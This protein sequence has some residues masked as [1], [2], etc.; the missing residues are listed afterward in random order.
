MQQYN[1]FLSKVKRIIIPLPDFNFFH[2]A[3]QDGDVDDK[4]VG[5]N[6]I[7][8]ILENWLR[9]P[10]TTNDDRNNKTADC[11]GS[12]LITGYRGM[13]KTSF[14]GKVI[15]KL[16]KEQ[17]SKWYM[18]WGSSNSK[19]RLAFMCMSPILT[20]YLVYYILQIF[21]IIQV[22]TLL[23]SEEQIRSIITISIVAPIYLIIVIILL[24]KTAPII[25]R[26][27]RNILK[28]KINIGNEVSDIRDIF[29]LFAYS[30]KDRLKDHI[31]EIYV[32]SPT[33]IAF[34]LL[35][36]LVIGSCSLILFVN[37]ISILTIGTDKFYEET[38][39]SLIFKLLEYFNNVG[40]GLL[41]GDILSKFIIVTIGFAY[42]TSVAYLIWWGIKKISVR[43]THAWNNQRYQLPEV[44]LNKMKQL[45]DRIDSSISEDN[46]PYG[47]ISIASTINVMYRRKKTHQYQYASVREI[48]YELIEI[49]KEINKSKL[50]NCRFIFVLDELDKLCTSKDKSSSE[51]LSADLPG[52]TN[53]DNGM[54]DEMTANEKRHNTLKLLS[55]LKYFV[56]TAEAK[57][58]FIAGHELYDAYK[59]DVSDREFSISSIF[60]GVINVNSFF[61][62]DSR[63]KDVTRM[64]ETYLC[65]VLF[66]EEPILINSSKDERDRFRLGEYRKRIG[67]LN[68][69]KVQEAKEVESVMCLL[70]QF[71]TYLTFVS[72]GAPKKLSARLERYII[73]A[74]KFNKEH[75]T[76]DSIVV[77]LKAGRQDIKYYLS[78]G[79]HDRQKVGFVHNMAAP[80]FDNIISPSSDYGDKFLV[81]S[82]FLIAHIYKH[83][84]SGFS[85]RNLEYLPELMDTN[86]TPELREFISSIID[87]LGKVHLTNITSGIFTYKFPMK[88]AEEIAI[89]TK[90]SDELSA[91]FNFSLDYFASVKKYYYRLIEFY[92]KRDGQNGIISSIH[93]NLGDIHMANDE[94]SE[95]IV[96]YRHAVAIIEKELDKI[97]QNDDIHTSGNYASYIIRYA[98]M[99]LKLGLA[100]E[101]RNT[102]DSAHMIYTRLCSRLIAYRAIDETKIGLTHYFENSPDPNYVKNNWQGKVAILTKGPDAD[103][104]QSKLDFQ[105]KCYPVVID[106][107]VTDSYQFWMYGGELVNNLCEFLTP[108]KHSLITKLSVFEDL[109]IAYL[110]ILAKLLALE[111]HNICGITKDNI[112]IAEAEFQHLYI[113][114]N[115]VDKYLL[116]VDFFRKLGDIMYYKNNSYKDNTIHSLMYAME[117]WGYDLRGSIFN[118]CYRRKMTKVQ[119]EPLIEAF[120][121]NLN[122]A[123]ISNSDELVSAIVCE[124]SHK[125]PVDQ[126]HV[127]NIIDEMPQGI[128]SNINR[129]KECDQR[130]SNLKC[131]PCYACKYYKR[132]LN[133]LK[134]NLLNIS[135]IQLSEIR[136]SDS[137][138]FWYALD[139]ELLFSCRFNELIQTALSL[140]S[141]GNVMLSCGAVGNDDIINPLNGHLLEA[142]FINNNNASNFI[143]AISG[144]AEYLSNIDKAILYYWVAM[145]YYSKAGNYKESMQ[146]LTKIFNTISSYDAMI[147]KHKKDPLSFSSPESLF[148]SMHEV[149][150]ETIRN[151]AQLRAFDNTLE[152]QKL[153]KILDSKDD[154]NLGLT[155]MLPEIEEMLLAY[156]EVMLSQLDD[157][158]DRLFTLIKMFYNSPSLTYLRNDSM[159]Y[160]RV[161]SLMFKAR[162]NERVLSLLGLDFKSPTNDINANLHNQIVDRIFNGLNHSNKE[163]TLAFLI[164]DSIFCLINITDF[165]RSSVKT[166]LFSDS[167]CYG[168]YKRLYYWVRWKEYVEKNLKKV[169]DIMS[170]YSHWLYEGHHHLMLT[171]TYMSGMAHKH[172]EAA[173]SMHSEGSEYQ[174]FIRN[175]FIM[176]D[177][178]QN[179]TCQFYFALERVKLNSDYF[180]DVESDHYCNDC[181][182]PDNYYLS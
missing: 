136:L 159:I 48:E 88:L 4:F 134:N 114:T 45:C 83:H 44:Y 55:Q 26:Q 57:F 155:S 181:Y 154:I 144:K 170:D 140:E 125:L 108:D 90:K 111:K 162:L 29:S 63:I 147:T 113:I 153:K 10:H 42:A 24:V 14:V 33:N 91:I 107:S 173:E 105:K 32:K 148:A 143:N 110:P 141:M 35:K 30:V 72:N 180:K 179:N 97:S 5:R 126:C 58:V 62:Y 54:S 171:E 150:K 137:I 116:R 109:R 123:R 104:A 120:K 175:M 8:A 28:V 177:D 99:M 21:N 135:N 87:Y 138:C 11:T 115:S 60:N 18:R 133:H 152:V 82:S 23:H 92:T 168:V 2:R 52:F 38:N 43:L 20:L 15:D 19:M 6:N 27:S 67:T 158:D 56:S 160:N 49:I 167:F 81:S 130:R 118:Y 75:N 176:D 77:R 119:T 50:L 46:S 12:Y 73:S 61:S 36:H 74:D 172:Y 47:D 85:W 79:Y 13:G 165:I 163:Q 64:T 59:A 174:S 84:K 1:K 31:Q 95:A 70:K 161:V 39:S 156:Y 25:R 146:A 127:R 102:I 66:G 69:D 145:K 9:V 149:V 3:S 131:C 169:S 16:D 76:G 106:K 100:Y 157:R 112:K 96:Q 98:R 166:T 51:S 117:C 34:R 71:V 132:S 65:K 121:K 129:I 41:H 17:S 182:K 139:N 103:I 142:V 164:S 80:I 86:R 40:I 78:L 68:A 151:V 122:F 178:L 93:H 124:S 37:S 22:N 94:F 128:R 101:K 53:D 7:S 89:F